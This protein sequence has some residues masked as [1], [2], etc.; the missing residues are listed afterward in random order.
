MVKKQDLH[1]AYPIFS[2]N[3]IINYNRNI[4]SQYQ[5]ERRSREETRGC[6]CGK[7]KEMMDELKECGGRYEGIKKPNS[8]GSI[9]PL[10]FIKTKYLFALLKGIKSLVSTSKKRSWSTLAWIWRDPLYCLLTYYGIIWC[11]SS[12]LLSLQKYRVVVS[13]SLLP[14]TQQSLNHLISPKSKPDVGD[15]NYSK[16]VLLRLMITQN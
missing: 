15:Q 10:Y 11:T 6:W 1:L 7:E 2:T 14:P 8:N 12:F 4:C 13:M 5:P 16:G 3:S 9:P